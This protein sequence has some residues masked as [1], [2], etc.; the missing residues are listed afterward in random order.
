MYLEAAGET[1]DSDGEAISVDESGEGGKRER[2]PNAMRGMRDR[3]RGG[4]RPV[5]SGSGDGDA[6]DDG[7][8]AWGQEGTTGSSRTGVTR[9][10]NTTEKVKEKQ[11]DKEA[12][13]KARAERAA[14]K[15]QDAEDKEERRRMTQVKSC[16]NALLDKLEKNLA[17]EVRHIFRVIPIHRILIACDFRLSGLAVLLQLASLLELLLDRVS[18]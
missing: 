13:A 1:M 16:M 17:K 3:E 12:R 6:Y 9:Q 8:E 2:D 18:A 4:T 7:D 14:K 11:L 15:K 10:R 5:G